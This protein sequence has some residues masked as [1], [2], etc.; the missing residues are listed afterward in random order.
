VTAIGADGSSVTA[1][2]SMQAFQPAQTALAS[3]FYQYQADLLGLSANTRYSYT[4]SVDGQNLASDPTLFHFRTAGAG[5]FSFLVIGD[6]GAASAE[7]MSLIQMMAAEP[8]VAMAVHVGD[9][10]YSD[11]TFAEFETNYFQPNAPLMR[12]LGFF[13]TPG[14]HEYMTDQAA[15]YLAGV[16]TPAGSVPTTDLGRY[17]SFDWGS[18]HFVSLDSNY[19]MTG[20]AQGMLAWLDADLAATTQRWRIVF[21]HHPPYPSGYHVGDP[22]CIAVAQQVV[23]IVE[24]HG[25]QLVLSGHEHAFERTYPLA[26][27]V[28]VDFPSP[29]TMYVIT[30]GGG[31]GLEP[32]GSVPQCAM[33]VEAFN[34]LRVDV[35]HESIR[36]RATGLNGEEID[37]ITL[38][39]ARGVAISKIYSVGGYTP[40][41]ASGSL[42]AIMGEKLATHTAA[43]SS[44]PTPGI[45][46]GVVVTANGVVAPLRRV[47]PTEINAQLP[48]EVSGNVEVQVMTPEGSASTSVTVLPA[49]PSLLEVRSANRPLHF[50]N[51][52]RPGAIARLY[53]TGLGILDESSAA[54]ASLEV[55]LGKTRLQPSFAGAE[56]GRAGVYRIDVAIPP[57]LADG[58]YSLQVVAGSVS[59]R[60]T[61]LDVAA[62]A[63]R[64][65]NDRGLLK[66]E[67]RS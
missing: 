24:R 17:Y 34:Y 46:G 20:G 38:G 28:P 15:P 36:L 56:P 14:N 58:L 8:D 1:A 44:Q 50:C 23:P 39:S 41:V 62:T 4:V 29:S 6:S 7:Q 54:L 49:A 42:I 48:Y 32:V 5:K 47:S 35:E 30:G 43:G 18:A 67:V 13:S 37:D 12:S 64:A 63:T 65:R 52:V 26:G 11:G 19:L 3:T 25:V 66:V 31:A 9:L 33:S 16:A 22:V 53:L 51:P 10:A 55:W 61:T 40:A 60:P 2:A 59:S 45:L 57:G 27:G 21:L